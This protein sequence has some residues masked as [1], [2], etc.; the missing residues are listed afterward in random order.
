[1]SKEPKISKREVSETLGI[2]ETAVDKHI[3]K[4][5]KLG[6]IERIGPAKGGH[7]EVLK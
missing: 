3:E 1:M 6:I 2:S 7:W 5:K 4:L